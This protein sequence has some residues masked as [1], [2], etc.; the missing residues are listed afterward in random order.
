VLL[1][2]VALAPDERYRARGAEDEHAEIAFPRE[3]IVPISRRIDVQSQL[4]P[5]SSTCSEPSGSNVQHFCEMHEQDGS[6]PH[7][8]GSGLHCVDV[9]LISQY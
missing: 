7:A 9:A 1:V 2:D 8:L 3:K 6:L 4:F 5:G